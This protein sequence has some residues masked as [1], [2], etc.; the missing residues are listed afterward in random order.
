[1]TKG[2]FICSTCY[3]HNQFFDI[4]FKERN[5]T[6]ILPN[7]EVA[8]DLYTYTYNFKATFSSK[9]YFLRKYISSYYYL[10]LN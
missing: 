7:Y 4:L 10:T 8:G 2:C 3:R 5:K 9:H 6:H 1:M